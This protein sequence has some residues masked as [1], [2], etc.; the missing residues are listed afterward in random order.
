MKIMLIGKTGQ[1]GWELERTLAPLGKVSAWGEAELDITNSALL[2]KTIQQVSPDLI[3]NAAAYT[4]VDRAEQD[5][6]LSEQV[7]GFATG[8]MAETAK[9][10]GAVLI[11]ISTDYVFDGTKGSAYLETDIPNPIN[12]YGRSKLRGE[13]VIQQ[14]GGSYLILRTS[15]VY[16]Q[17]S[18]NFVTKVL[19]WARKQ[20]QLRI[21]ADQIGNPTWARLLAE[22]ITVLVARAGVDPM[23]YFGQRSGIYHLAGRGAASRY[24]WAQAALE[25][26][27]QRDEQVVQTLEPV[28]TSAFPTPAIRPLFTALNCT[29]FE[30]TFQLEIPS[31]RESLQLALKSIP[32]R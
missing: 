15:C 27:P 6:E 3:I 28:T 14:V 21:V 9:I 11:H 2:A 22:T 31:W 13:Q 10:L 29:H 32:S 7:N 4:A 16:N 24:E 17:W 1:V 5:V 26:D 19:A 30:K 23:Q 18:D 20:A 12:Q 25:F 8:V